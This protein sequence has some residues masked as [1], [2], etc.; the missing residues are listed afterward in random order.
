MVKRKGRYELLK[1]SGHVGVWDTKSKK[2]LG[3]LNPKKQIMVK[4][5]ASAYEKGYTYRSSTD[6][7]ER[8]GK[9]RTVSAKE[10]KKLRA[11]YG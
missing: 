6:L 8:V 3:N 1:M 11:R 7:H 10:L 9:R 4:T 2:R 5:P